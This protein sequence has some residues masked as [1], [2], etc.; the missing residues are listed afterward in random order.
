MVARSAAPPSD[1]QMVW[2]DA[3]R[4]PSP[5]VWALGGLIGNDPPSFP[6]VVRLVGGNPP[7]SFPPCSVGSGPLPPY[8]LWCGVWCPPL[9]AGKSWWGRI[10]G[11]S[12][13]GSPGGREVSL[14]R[15]TIF[16]GR[17]FHSETLGCPFRCFGKPWRF[18]LGTI[19]YRI[20]ESF[21]MTSRPLII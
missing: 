1:P 7:P 17:R 11:P 13:E 5:E 16:F 21:V 18:L 4:P 12:R 2:E 19:Q 20:M 8:L 10:R 6:C 3:P 15:Q 14:V 9:R